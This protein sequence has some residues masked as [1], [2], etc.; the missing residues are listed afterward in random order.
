MSKV[1]QPPGVRMLAVGLCHM[2]QAVYGGSA[3][4]EEAPRNIGIRAPTG[5]GGGKTLVGFV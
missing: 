4:V 3:K 1:A 2:V 5:C